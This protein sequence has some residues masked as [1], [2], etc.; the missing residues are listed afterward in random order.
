M[1]RSDKFDG[2]DLWDELFRI[3]DEQRERRVGAG[4]VQQAFG[5]VGGGN[6]HAER[7][8]RP[9]EGRD[10]VGEGGPEELRGGDHS[11]NYSKRSRTLRPEVKDLT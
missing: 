11:S 1:V 10:L 6:R 5:G 2:L 9:G 4:V 8:D 3:R 7:R